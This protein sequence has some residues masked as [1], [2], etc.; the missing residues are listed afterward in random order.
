M[1]LH[2]TGT[3]AIQNALNFFQINGDLRKHKFQAHTNTINH[4][5][6]E[7]LH[8]PQNKESIS[9]RLYT[10]LR[11]YTTSPLE[12]IQD[13]IILSSETLCVKWG[14][15]D[16]ELSGFFAPFF[17]DFFKGHSV[18]IIV[19]LRRQ[20]TYLESFYAQKAKYGMLNERMFSEKKLQRSLYYK[21]FLDSWAQFFGKENII[22]RVYEK[23]KLYRN[24]AVNDFF[25]IIGLK[26]INIQS[27]YTESNPSLS[28]EALRIRYL[29]DNDFTLNS[30]ERYKKLNKLK[31]ELESGILD[32]DTYT[33]RKHCLLMGLDYD[34]ACKYSILY[35]LFTLERTGNFS[36]SGFMHPDERRAFLSQYEE[37]NRAIAREY[38]G[39]N[40][41]ELFDNTFP[42]NIIS[43]DAPNSSDIIRIFV[44]IIQHLFEKIT[45]SENKIHELESV[46]EQFLTNRKN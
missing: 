31:S 34:F 43:L 1:G 4:F 27:I 28:A 21:K 18:K 30:S 42:Q 37:D 39:K 22:V 33:F 12:N 13:N 26:N 17:Y 6:H 14:D 35:K 19:Y 15:N 41:E 20:D 38:L 44:P 2:K 29:F 45:V 9:A 3:S 7:L 23:A 24:D 25:H 46:I 40:G 11:T 32:V 36:N 5:A 10:I 16:C 8:F